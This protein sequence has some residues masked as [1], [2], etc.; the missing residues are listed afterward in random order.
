MKSSES[1][2]NHIIADYQARK[3]DQSQVCIRE[4][5]GVFKMP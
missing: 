4:I 5:A 3:M 1:R 2:K